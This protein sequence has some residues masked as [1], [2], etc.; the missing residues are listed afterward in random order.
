MSE[1][2]ST[3]AATCPVA[4][5]A[6]EL[7]RVIQA[8]GRVEDAKVGVTGRAYHDLEAQEQALRDR[9]YALEDAASHEVA[10]SWPG[11]MIQIM[12]LL[13]D[14]ERV[15][16]YADPDYGGEAGQLHRKASRL[17][18]SLMTFMER[19]S[20]LNRDDFAGDFYISR[21]FDPHAQFERA[22]AA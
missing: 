7:H 14:F 1:A 20:G 16:S 17:A 4:E 10:A 6:A 8:S 13:N 3:P 11:A 19:T 22:L 5:M 2:I 9:Q 18:Y 12:L 15:A 21:D